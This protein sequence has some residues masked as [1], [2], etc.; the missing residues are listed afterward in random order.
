MK[1]K[2]LYFRSIEDKFCKPLE[3]FIH[4][5]KIDGLDKITLIEA[6]PNFQDPEHIFCGHEGE[7]V[8]RQECK[9]A[10]C[11][12]Y[13]SVNGRGVCEHRGRLYQHGEEVEFDVP[14]I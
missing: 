9:K 11:A 13:S 5:A 4:D 3:G 8:E 7:V 6:I 2:K 10:Q 12:S 1:L 14:K